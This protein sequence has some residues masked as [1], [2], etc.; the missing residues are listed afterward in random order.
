MPI[1]LN[2]PFRNESP[3]L[4]FVIKTHRVLNA[5]KQLHAYNR[6]FSPG[7]V[8]L[9]H[10]AYDMRGACVSWRAHPTGVWIIQ[11]SAIN[12]MTDRTQRSIAYRRIEVVALTPAGRVRLIRAQRIS[13]HLLF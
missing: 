5:G 8:D 6:L 2:A 3:D 10:H 11:V 12:H 4:A 7:E 13:K 1:S 9:T